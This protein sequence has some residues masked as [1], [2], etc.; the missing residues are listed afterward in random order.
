MRGQFFGYL[1]IGLVL[2]FSIYLVWL[3]LA[4]FWSVFSDMLNNRELDQLAD[5]YA[6]R[7][8][9]RMAENSVRLEN[10]CSHVFNDPLGAL[11]NDVCMRCGLAKE[12]PL[13]KCD[14]VWRILP[15]PIPSSE[16]EKCGER[17]CRTET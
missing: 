12:R 17:F 14:H 1:A 3:V 9:E 8:K 10:G 13:T 4:A 6:G 2:L 11:P 7:R 16:C 15:D 5:E